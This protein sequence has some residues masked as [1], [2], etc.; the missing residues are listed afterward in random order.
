MG[1]ATQARRASL[2]VMVGRNLVVMAVGCS[3]RNAP[4]VRRRLLAA[5]VIAVA[6][7]V[8]CSKSP[9]AP[10]ALSSVPGA[11]AAGDFSTCALTNAGAAYCCGR[12]QEGQLG[13]G[14]SARCVGGQCVGGNPH[15]T[16]VAS[17]GGH[18]F[19]V[20]A[21]G[22][23]FMCALIESGAP[24][25]WG[26]QFESNTGVLFDATVPT[27]VSDAPPLVVMAAGAFHACGLTI[28]GAAYCWGANDNGQLGTGDLT[29]HRGAVP[30]AGTLRFV[31]I[32]VGFFQTCALTAAGAGY[33][34]GG[35][36]FGELGNPAAG[37]SQPTPIA[38]A[39]GLVFARLYAGSGYGCA[40]TSGGAAYCW[41]DNTAGELGDG[42]QTA[43][44]TPVAV[45]GGLTFAAIVPYLGNSLLNHTCGITT[46]HTAYCWGA[47][48][49]GALGTST[50]PATCAFKNFSPFTCSVLPVPV[51]GGHDF[52]ALSLGWAHTCGITT[53]G[54]GYCW[55]Q[56]DQGQ[57]GDSSTTSRTTPVPIRGNLA[58]Q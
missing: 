35:N 2:S 25:C 38:I 3:L 48:D 29:G 27:P 21:G 19:S 31:S 33:C 22:G 52:S 55:G 7:L 43:R 37:Y 17:V 20:L 53:D 36:S 42:T 50:V 9:S 46:D 39:G 58:L 40:L 54:I 4:P 14:D 10:H 57:V 56:N 23:D 16:P 18:S 15:T 41:G 13:I 11:L 6:G 34:W 51:A 5:I 28:R 12:D 24:W 44:T 45:S 1:T 26:R 49:S 47:A 32:S 30:V 8:S